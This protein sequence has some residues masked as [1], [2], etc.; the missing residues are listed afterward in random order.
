M[1]L[2]IKRQKGKT[3][4]NKL[5]KLIMQKSLLFQIRRSKY[6][7]LMY[8]IHAKEKNIQILSNIP[9]KLN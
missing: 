3:L 5:A 1:V 4:Q 7:P 8:T 6:V 2:D 9:D